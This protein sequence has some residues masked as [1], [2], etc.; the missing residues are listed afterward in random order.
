[1]APKP[2]VRALV[3][4][5]AVL[6]LLAGC[7]SW[8]Q[9]QQRAAQARLARERCINRRNTISERLEPIRADQRVLQSIADERYSASPQPP[10]PDPQNASRYSQ[11]DR[12][13]DEERY[14]DELSAWRAAEEQRR[15]RW[16]QAQNERRQQAEQQLSAHLKELAAIE[17]ELVRNGQTNEPAIA[18]V[19]N[20]DAPSDATVSS[21]ASSQGPRR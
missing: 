5:A 9:E 14:Q 17:P 7:G 21:Q 3:L 13:L 18:R 1:M 2:G 16:Q 19:S 11:L 4:S 8:W 6:L 15:A 20:C 12:E 10:A